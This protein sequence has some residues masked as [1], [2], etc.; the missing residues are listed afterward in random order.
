MFLEQKSLET[1]YSQKIGSGF[2]KAHIFNSNDSTTYIYNG[3][4]SKTYISIFG[5]ISF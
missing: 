3:L 4:V 2:A 1:L 5:F